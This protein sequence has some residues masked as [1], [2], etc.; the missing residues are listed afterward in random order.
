MIPVNAVIGNSDRPRHLSG[1]VSYRELSPTNSG[2]I[3]DCLSTLMRSRYQ[4]EYFD[5]GN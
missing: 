5:I 3:K 2:G 4:N 1:C